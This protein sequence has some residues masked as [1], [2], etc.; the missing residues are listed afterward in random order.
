MRMIGIGLGTALGMAASVMGA[1]LAA[2]PGEAGAATVHER[3][4]TLDTHLDTPLHLMRPGWDIAERHDYVA[5]NSQVDIPRMIEGGLDGGF[6]VIW[7]PQGELTEEGY[8][9]AAAMAAVR[10][11]MILAM[12]AANSDALEHARTA[13][14][15]ARIAAAGRRFVYQSIEN[16][17][18]LGEDIGALQRFYDNGVRMVGPVHSA[19]NQFA[20]SATG[21]E[22]WGGLSP[23]GREL[24]AEMNRL[25]IIPDGSHASDAAFDQMVELSA[26][27]I[28]LSHSGPKAAH[29]HPRNIDDARIRRLAESGGVI[30]VN[31][32]YLAP[33]SNSPEWQAMSRRFMEMFSESR[34]TQDAFV[35]DLRALEAVTPR[36]DADF[37]MFMASLMHLIDVA[38]VDHVAFGADWDGG[39]GVENMRDITALPMITARLLAAGH[40][41][42]DLA[43]MWSG[44]VLRL[45]RAAEEHAASHGG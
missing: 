15:A 13:D 10:Q 7:T 24:I 23:L 31:S 6:F 21:E 41:E 19:S 20:D 1:P 30:A 11:Q 39:G 35:R 38:G 8:G 32:I 9:N 18:P 22:L 44:N 14:D 37:E 45:L 27:P 2:Q 40:D 17:Y 42:S 43:K 12:I 36:E 5:D 16:S 25:G 33:R 34:E 3:L 26:T 29:D 28:I 4:L